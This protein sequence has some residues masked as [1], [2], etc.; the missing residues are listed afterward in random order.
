MEIAITA[1]NSRLS[2]S[3]ELVSAVN[4]HG[5]ST[6]ARGRY[7]FGSDHGITSKSQVEGDGFDFRKR[8]HKFSAIVSTV[9]PQ[10]VE[11]PCVR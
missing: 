7:R 11:M 4:G 8:H 2:K 10:N 5:H 3:S 1:L 9:S 6:T